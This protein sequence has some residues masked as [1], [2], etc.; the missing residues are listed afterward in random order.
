MR[1]PR[2]LR[3]DAAP[4]TAVLLA[5][6]PEWEKYI[7]AGATPNAEATALRASVIASRACAPFA[8][9]ALGLP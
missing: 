7:S 4:N 2:F 3:A 6:V 9:T 5:S 1:P 8:W